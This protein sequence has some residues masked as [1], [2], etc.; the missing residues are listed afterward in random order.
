MSSLFFLYTILS[1]VSVLGYGLL[2]KNLFDIKSELSYGLTGLLGLF[3]LSQIS[4]ITH[5]FLSHSY[6]HN[7]AIL[8]FGIL[9]FV[10]Y[11]FSKN[12]KN[13]DP[14]ILIVCFFSIILGF[15]IA[16]TNEDFP[17]Y[18][19]PN[20]LQFT[21]NKIEFGL[22]NLNH[23][24]KHT[25]SLFLLNSIFYFPKKDFYLF[26]L[27]NFLFL[28]FSIDYLIFK[29]FNKKKKEFN[30]S[31]IL[32]IFSLILILTKFS[33]LAEY[34]TD[35]AG[36]ILIIFVLIS[37]LNFILTKNLVYNEKKEEFLVSIIFILFALTT[38]IYFLLYFLF[39]VVVF[40]R[41]RNKKQV[42]ND[43][44]FSKNIFLLIVPIITTL[45]FNFSSTGCII[46]PIAPTC[47]VNTF[48]WGLKINVVEYLN[49][50]YELWTKGG[51]SPIFSTSN[52]DEY[53][54]RFNWLA[55]WFSSYFFNKVSDFILVLLTFIVIFYL[56][57]KNNI[58]KKMKLKKVNIN[59]IFF[60]SI[61]LFLFLI[62][63]YKF[64][65]LRYGGYVLVFFLLIYPF[66]YF[67]SQRINL[68]AP[69]VKKKIIYLI[70]FSFLIFNI[71]NTIRIN[72]EFNSENLNNFKN[73]PLFY[74]GNKSVNEKL[75]NG[76]EVNKVS[77]MC[78]ATKPL[79]TRST[80]FEILVKKGYKFYYKNEK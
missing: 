2:F 71:K 57:F 1:L 35:L 66:S 76:F 33:R 70:V 14:K 69:L 51:R 56:T 47:F 3:F 17:Y 5:L 23:G 15:L 59:Y 55:N 7:I 39:P 36:Q 18:H 43:L 25:S 54:A 50:H 68:E 30:I 26:N 32:Y 9:T 67:L 42:F 16:K 40:L 64:P 41:C 4:S 11:H 13:V 29:I 22:G 62:W 27:T 45:F 12:V 21:F 20:S 34:G 77:G 61:I 65:Q 75:I 48:D 44:V 79:C 37:S 49:T 10:F 63:F 80:D 74:V 72:K 24:F 78:W 31:K 58:S 46:Y 8:M 52:P 6:I 19:L 60:Y 38:K 28:L 73:F 53:L